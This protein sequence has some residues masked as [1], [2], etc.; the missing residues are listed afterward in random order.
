LSTVFVLTGAL[1]NA[2]AFAD[3]PVTRSEA[4][5]R[6]KTWMTAW[7]GGPVPYS[8]TAKYQGWRQ[9]CSG[10][11]SMAWN[12]PQGSGGGPNTVALLNDGWVRPIN[13]DDLM[14]GDAIGFLGDGSAGA[15]GHV[16]LFERW[17]D[18]QRTT[19]WVY[20]QAGDGG[21]K[22]R[23]HARSYNGYK[24]YRYKDIRDDA[25]AVQHP[26]ASGRVVSGR[27]ADGRLETFAA[28]ADGVYHA[29]Q[30]RVNGGWSPWERLGGPRNA[31][32]AIATT[33]D[34][35]LE[36]FAV[37]EATF[38]HMWQTARSGGWS[39][40]E[41][42]GGGGYRVAVG[43]NADGR[44][45]VFASNPNGVFHKWQNWF[46]SWS[47][48]AGVG[49]PGNSRLD[50]EAAPD[51]RLEVFALS[52][53]TFGHLFQTAR[54]GGW[55]QWENFGGGGHALTVNHN[56]DGRLEVFASNPNGVS[57][58]W[59]TNLTS[60]SNWEGA[61]GGPASAELSSARTA[62][63]R[64]EVYA[65]NGQTASH[66]WQT[67]QNKPYSGWEAFGGGGTSVTA[68]NNADGRI[69]VFG[70][71]HAGVYHKWQTTYS[72][73]SDWA[74]LNGPGPAMD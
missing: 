57:H 51:G 52:D 70:T 25:P 35:R 13:W 28:S 45:E 61:S 67:G 62:D 38:D 54:N 27:S 4:I 47:A 23:T 2:P 31:Q 39:G 19:Y 53:A 37:S 36:V 43:N 17:D 3:N 72:A 6:A 22:H 74:W 18:A 26:Y 48:W 46:S 71:S 63:G 44:I 66:I 24:P 65:M 32:L 14:P 68:A 73:W 34:G 15:A 1:G 58:R 42:F 12:L 40:W 29:W 50:M 21:T 9:D 7:N 5:D 11:V 56:T 30:T 41:N 16:M 55:S 69:E 8:M 59:Q 64:V 10:Y 33:S 49:G 60:W 20:E